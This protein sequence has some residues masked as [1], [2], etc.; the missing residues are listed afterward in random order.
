[1]LDAHGTH[2]TL[3]VSAKSCAPVYVE[4]FGAGNIAD[5]RTEVSEKN[6]HADSSRS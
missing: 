5:T 2:L 1:L 4:A 3:D 6:I